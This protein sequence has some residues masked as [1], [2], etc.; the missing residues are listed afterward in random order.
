MDGNHLEQLTHPVSIAQSLQSFL[1]FT[2]SIG[3]RPGE[4]IWARAAIPSRS[5]HS[6]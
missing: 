3:L 4:C 6:P 1:D 5:S 2:I